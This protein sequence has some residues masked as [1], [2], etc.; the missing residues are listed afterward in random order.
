MLHEARTLAAISA[1]SEEA[2]VSPACAKA[3]GLRYVSDAS[4]G[5]HRK[6]V[7]K[8]FRYV[9][10]AGRPIRDEETLRRIRSLAIPPAYEQVWI[11]PDPRGHIQATARDAKG[12]K[13]YRYHPRWREL[14]DAVKFHRMLAFA[15]ALPTIREKTDRDLALPGMPR[16]KVLATVVRLLEET[17]IRVGNDEYARRNSSY[18]LT[19]LQNRHATVVGST[20]RFAFRGKSGKDHNVRVTDR[21]VAK[22]VRRCLDIPG[23]ELFQYLY[24]SGARRAIDSADMNDYLQAIAGD[25][26]TA[27]DFRTWSGTVL[28]AELLVAAGAC[29]SQRDGTRK[30]RAALEE[31]ARRLGN[32]PAVCKKSY[33]HPDVLTSFLD[34]SIAQLA[35]E[36]ESSFPYDLCARERFVV[37]LLGACANKS[38]KAG[39]LGQQ[40]ARSL[41]A[42]KSGKK[43]AA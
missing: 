15:D 11:C 39:T 35:L 7:G 38:K 19:T 33:V 17:R 1:V 13:Q 43:R 20:V 31:V 12:R 40:L 30:V 23:Q 22:I 18:G 42:E 9:D 10:A 3:A 14:R 29:A 41:K 32:T 28:A 6:R 8:A 25:S 24:D 27:K 4:R 26:F 16:E 36:R 2:E 34:G 21:R 5:L 37:A